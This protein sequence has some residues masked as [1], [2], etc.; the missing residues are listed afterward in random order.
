MAM[1]AGLTPLRR[2]A[3][4]ALMAGTP[5]FAQALRGTIEPDGT[6][7]VPAFALAPSPDSALSLSGRLSVAIRMPS[8]SPV[9]RW[10]ASD[11]STPQPRERGCPSARSAIMLRWTSLVPP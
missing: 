5:A 1:V 10:G 4:V 3:C 7:N 9:S 2:L 11:I 8:C 6:A